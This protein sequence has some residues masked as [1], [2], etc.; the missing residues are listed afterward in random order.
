M[1]SILDRN[2]TVYNESVVRGI[3][4]AAQSINGT[5]VHDY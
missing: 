5:K 2:D 4:T 1:S 3:S